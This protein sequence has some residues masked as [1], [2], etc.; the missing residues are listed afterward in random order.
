MYEFFMAA[1]NQPY[2][3]GLL[4]ILGLALLEGVGLLVGLSLMGWLDDITPF[5][6]DANTDA[7]ATSVPGL[8]AFLGW[9]CLSRLPLLIWL[10]LFTTCFVVSGYSIN[11][12]W[13]NLSQSLL[14]IAISVPLSLLL[15][16]YCTHLL[17]KQLAKVMP[18]TT[19]DAVSEFSFSGAVAELTQNGCTKGRPVEASFVDNMGTVQQVLV[20]LMDDSV[21]LNQGDKVVLSEADDRG[22]WLGVPL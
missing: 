11:Y 17:G 3:F 2:T 9:L 22:I 12:L 7:S 8:T 14:W 16:V 5:D 10:I 6:I 18:T 15:A 20:Q 19:S 21:T 4:F 1:Q 13:L